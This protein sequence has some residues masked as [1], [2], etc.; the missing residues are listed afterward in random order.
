MRGDLNIMDNYVN[1]YLNKK[2]NR[3]NNFN[4]KGAKHGE[5]NEIVAYKQS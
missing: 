2:K 3:G 1:Y 4:C 5:R